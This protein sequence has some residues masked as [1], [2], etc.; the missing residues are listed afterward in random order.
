[1]YRR[2]RYLFDR[3]MENILGSSGVRNAEGDTDE[4]STD[5]GKERIPVKYRFRKW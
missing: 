1:M 2:F 5:M 3:E 4:L